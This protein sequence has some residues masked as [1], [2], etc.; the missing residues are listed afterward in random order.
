MKKLLF[1]PLAAMILLSACR[2]D[3]DPEPDPGPTDGPADTST[4][5]FDL[6]LVPYDSLS[7]YHF[8]QGPLAQFQPSNGVIPF[9]PIN[10]LFS[11]YAHKKRFLW[12]PP[13]AGA[14]YESDSSSF[15][16]P[17]GAVMIKTFSYD[18]VQP[19]DSHRILETRMLFKRNGVWEF[20]N[21]V[22]NAEQTEA[23]YDMT[24]HYVPLSFTD[25]AGHPHDVIYRI[26]TETECFTCHKKAGQIS[27]PIGP[28]PQNLNSTFAYADGSMNQLDKWTALGY[29][30]GGLPGSINT[31][32]D[33]TDPSQPLNERVRGYVDANCSHC[34]TDGRYCDYRPMRFAWAESSDPAML[35]VCV[36][37]HD[38]LLPIHSHI[39]KPGNLEKS[40]LYYR[41]NSDL[42]GIRMPLL[43]RTLIH[44]EGRQLIADWINSLTQTCN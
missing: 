40:L 30:E 25:D 26:P 12:M 18:H 15:I 43:G 5:S 19:D 10:A 4:V 36:E 9:A 34:H 35:G 21:Y 33:W 2:R 11:D 29:L 27:T 24:G 31:V 14:V 13:G 22:W 7:K 23:V 17:D 44:E 1:V 8:F 20:A 6:A 39:V 28:K 42:D 3:E 16:F 37:P 32:T 41:V 38:P